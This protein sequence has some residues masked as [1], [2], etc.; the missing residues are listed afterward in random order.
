MSPHV[1]QH[2][3]GHWARQAAARSTSWR[4]ARTFTSSVGAVGAALVGAA[5]VTGTTLFALWHGKAVDSELIAVVLLVSTINCGVGYMLRLGSASG[6]AGLA[7]LGA[8]LMLIET[9][10]PAVWFTGSFR[11]PVVAAVAVVALLISATRLATP[12]AW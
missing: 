5:G 6:A 10:A 12:K 11:L 7:V 1:K 8:G 9:I 4:L 2:I 3:R